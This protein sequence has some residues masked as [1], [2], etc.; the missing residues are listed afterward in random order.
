MF[1]NAKAIIAVSVLF[2]ISW[3]IDCVM[4]FSLAGWKPVVHDAVLI[5]GALVIG[6]TFGEG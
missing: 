4:G 6:D 5:F 3:G 1:L 2:L